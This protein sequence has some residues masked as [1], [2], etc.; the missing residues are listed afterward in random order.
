MSLIKMMLVMVSVAAISKTF[1]LLRF[2][3]RLIFF[4]LMIRR[5]PRSTLFPYTTLFRSLYVL[6]ERFDQHEQERYARF[7]PEERETAKQGLRIALRDAIKD[8]VSLVAGT[9]VAPGK[10]GRAHV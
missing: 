10:I 7:I 5:P 1:G 3:T 9:E 8:R 4:F 6:D 2:S